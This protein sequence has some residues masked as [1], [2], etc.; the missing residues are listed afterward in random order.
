MRLSFTDQRNDLAAEDHHLLQLGPAGD[1]EL[2]HADFLVLEERL[3]TSGVL[4]EPD[5]LPPPVGLVNYMQRRCNRR[6]TLVR[7]ESEQEPG[8]A[9]AWSLDSEYMLRY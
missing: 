2:R 4:Y 1:D 7:I 8:A 9:A 3:S 6:K 5:W